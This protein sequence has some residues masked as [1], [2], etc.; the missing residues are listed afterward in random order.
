MTALL[1]PA[2]LLS[3]CSDKTEETP[4]PADPTPEYRIGHGYYYPATRESSIVSWPS[5]DIKGEA[6]LYPAVLGLDF[7]VA[8][9]AVHLE[10]DRAALK[11][12]WKG[13]Y[14]LKCQKRPTDPVFVSYLY[15]D[16]GGTSIFRLSD[17]TPELTGNVTITAYDAKRQ[18]LSGTYEVVAP[19]QRDPLSD[20]ST[21]T[22][23]ITLAGSFTDMKVK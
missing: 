5:R 13:V 21:A 19:G 3:A 8:T 15:T 11:T 1:V 10:V 4:A 9:D 16:A 18:L 23:D 14:A 12:D 2:G 6:Q 22:C 20:F 7:K 17:F